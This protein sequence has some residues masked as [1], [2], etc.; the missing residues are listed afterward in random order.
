MTENEFDIQTILTKRSDIQAD[1]ILLLGQV[2]EKKKKL[3]LRI[4]FKF[5]L[6]SR[7]NE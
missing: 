7:T 6:T 5:L 3:T 4:F 2:T 1:R